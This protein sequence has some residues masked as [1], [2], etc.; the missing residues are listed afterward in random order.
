M[1]NLSNYLESELAR[2]EAVVI[3]A[4]KGDKKLHEPT[5]ENHRGQ[6][7]ALKK[8]LFYAES[9]ETVLHHRPVEVVSYVSLSWS[10]IFFFVGT[11]AWH[12]TLSL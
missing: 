1:S 2:A 9:E 7:L 8:A 5:V 12:I 11:L 10:W 3:D 4:D 6:V